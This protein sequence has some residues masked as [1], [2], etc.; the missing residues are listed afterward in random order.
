MGSYLLGRI[1]TEHLLALESAR[2]A[3]ERD[4]INAIAG[5][6]AAIDAELAAIEIIARARE[7]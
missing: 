4:E 2:I 3:Q 5:E 7:R 1:T 6:A